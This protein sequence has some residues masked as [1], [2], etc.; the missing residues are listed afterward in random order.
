[1]DGNT[2]AAIDPAAGFGALELAGISLAPAIGPGHRHCQQ[3]PPVVHQDEAVHRTAKAYCHGR[4]TRRHLS[5]HLSQYGDDGIHQPFRVQLMTPA[6]ALYDG[7]RYL[8]TAEHLRLL[9]ECHGLCVRGADI[10]TDDCSHPGLFRSALSAS[11]PHT[12][13]LPAY[14]V[15]RRRTA[16]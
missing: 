3:S 13:P 10:Y 12:P 15:W 16:L 6:I 8:G 2:G 7:I 11:L 5:D 14:F 1:M 4:L 9:R